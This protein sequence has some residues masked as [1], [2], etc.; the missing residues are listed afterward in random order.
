MARTRDSHSLRESDGVPLDCGQ[1]LREHQT[2]ARTHLFSNF[3]ESNSLEVPASCLARETIRTA[4]PSDAGVIK[5]IDPISVRQGEGDI[6]L[7]EQDG[8]LASLPQHFQGLR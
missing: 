8:D 3:A 7:P 1:Q 5:Y 2:A 6:L 4:F